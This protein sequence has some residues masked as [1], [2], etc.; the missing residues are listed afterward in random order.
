MLL[1]N[2][3]MRKGFTG[4][5]KGQ[6]GSIGESSR[7]WGGRELSKWKG[8]NQR[9]YSS[10]MLIVYVIIAYSNCADRLCRLL[11]TNPLEVQASL[12][13]GE[14]TRFFCSFGKQ[15]SHLESHIHEALM[16]LAGTI[17]RSWF[18]DSWC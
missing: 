1:K 10:K 13:C 8:S 6:Y 7:P 4:T 3:S 17:I 2:R 15:R 16:K 18:V 11:L 9:I 14:E 5:G 12:D